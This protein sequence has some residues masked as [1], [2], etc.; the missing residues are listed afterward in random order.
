MQNVSKELLESVGVFQYGYVDTDRIEFKEEIQGI[1]RNNVCRVYGRT[2]A[3]PPAI[4]GIEECRSRCTR[5]SRALVF[6]GKY[7]LE[8]SYDYEGM[9]E[10]GEKFRCMCAR[11]FEGVE[12]TKKGYMLLANGGCNICEVCTYPDAPC[13][14]PHKMFMALE[15]QGIVVSDLCAM[16]GINYINGKDTVTYIGALFTEEKI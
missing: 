3:C 1:C 11:L 4:G 15:G 7:E 5:Y 10:A 12:G 9:V 6:S 14:H 13:R 16:A 8:D 2:W